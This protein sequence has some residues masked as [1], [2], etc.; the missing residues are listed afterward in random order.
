MDSLEG[1]KVYPRGQT[2][3]SEQRLNKLQ[4]P[5][6]G[7]GNALSHSIANRRE[8]ASYNSYGY[9]NDE[10]ADITTA[11]SQNMMQSKSGFTYYPG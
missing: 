11:A 3:G 2:A 7:R 9:G 6:G 10:R 8:Q 1:H 4:S 5:W